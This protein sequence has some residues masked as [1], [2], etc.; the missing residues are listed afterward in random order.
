MD[1]RRLGL[2]LGGVVFLG[3]PAAGTAGALAFSRPAT[4]V[5]VL[6]CREDSGG[7]RGWPP[8]GRKAG[9]VAVVR[10]RAEASRVYPEQPGVA[11]QVDF[12]TEAL[13]LVDIPKVWGDPVEVRRLRAG[14]GRVQCEVRVGS[15]TGVLSS[16]LRARVRWL[17]EEWEI[18]RIQTR[19]R[20]VIPGIALSSRYY[21]IRYWGKT[22]LYTTT[23]ALAV[24]K[25]HLATIDFEVIYPR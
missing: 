16:E 2:L 7:F 15:Q 22:T 23:L 20:F 3:L 5:R 17:V 9:R 14:P 19:L 11:D 21:P 13:V 6:G 24:R 18:F 1:R 4:E 25:D 8:T 12:R 10:S